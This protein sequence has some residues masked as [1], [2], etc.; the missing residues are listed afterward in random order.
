MEEH[1]RI[2]SQMRKGLLDFVVLASLKKEA[3]YPREIIGLLEKDGLNVVEGTLYPLFLR[4]MKQNLVSYEWRETCGHPRKYYSL[5]K[6]GKKALE[7]Y[8]TEWKSINTAI[9][10]LIK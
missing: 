1:N 7:L 6:D 8:E 4:I 2:K 10:H 5:T 3:R 9:N